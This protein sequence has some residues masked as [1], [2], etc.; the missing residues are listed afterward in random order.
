MKPIFTV[1]AG[2]YLF[3]EHIEN[4]YKG[5][6]LAW[7]P[8]KDTGIDFLLT[9]PKKKTQVSIQVKFSKDFRTIMSDE[10]KT[11]NQAC[12]WW[13]LNQEK[14]KNSPADYWVFVFNSFTESKNHFMM[15]KPKDLLKLLVD[16]HGDAKMIQTYFWVTGKNECW[17]TRGLSKEDQLKVAN[18][19]FRNSKRNVTNKLNDWKEIEKVLDF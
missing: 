5:K 8:S 19:T 14:I 7:L 16:L 10:L 6:I 4:A 18:G 2:E 15:I 17:E 1:H 11:G 9:N 13:T 3:G 12:G